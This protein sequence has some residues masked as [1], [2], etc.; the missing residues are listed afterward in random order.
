[1]YDGK[2]SGNTSYRSGGGVAIQH[3]I[4]NKIGGTI[5]GY[6][7]GNS[8][9]NTVKNNEEIVQQNQGHA[10][11]VYHWISNYGNNIYMGK[12]TTSG[13]TDNLSYFGA[14]TPPVWTGKW[15]YWYEG[16]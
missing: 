13:P 10:I 7:E 9:S 5:F 3:G 14:S 16:E 1:M 11:S 6:I 8:D 15:D 12:D 4:F 2:I